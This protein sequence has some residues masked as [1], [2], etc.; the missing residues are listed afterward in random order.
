[1]EEAAPMAPEAEAPEEAD[2]ALEEALGE[3]LVEA[4]TALEVALGEDPAEADTALEEAPG[5]VQALEEALGAGLDL[6]AQYLALK[7]E[8][9]VQ[10][11]AVA[12]G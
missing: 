2:T 9:L 10:G 4:D 6:G 3:D 1:M 8:A 11:K 7:G 12:P 5:E